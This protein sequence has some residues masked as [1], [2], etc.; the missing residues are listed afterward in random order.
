MQNFVVQQITS[1]FVLTL[2]VVVISSTDAHQH[3]PHDPVQD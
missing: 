1:I 3:N 2:L